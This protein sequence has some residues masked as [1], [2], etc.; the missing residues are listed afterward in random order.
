[1]NTKNLNK[2]D[3]LQLLAKITKQTAFNNELNKAVRKAIKKNPDLLMIE[4]TN[5]KG[6][7]VFVNLVLNF[8]NAIFKN[9]GE[10]KWLVI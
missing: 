4:E 8:K 9:L 10:K 2:G 1:M 6:E 5:E 7:S 3:A